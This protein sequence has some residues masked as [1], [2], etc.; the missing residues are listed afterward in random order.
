MQIGEIQIPDDC[1][2]LQQRSVPPGIDG[3]REKLRRDR[4]SV[5]KKQVN[6]K[7][8]SSIIMPNLNSTLEYES[9]KK[10]RSPINLMASELQ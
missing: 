10:E 9:S 3:F 5:N 7:R 8:G 2:P 4:I 6:K 1:L